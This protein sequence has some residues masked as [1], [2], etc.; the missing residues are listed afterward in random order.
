[1]KREEVREEGWGGRCMMEGKEWVAVDTVAQWAEG[2]RR[3]KKGKRWDR[4]SIR[5]V[6][7]LLF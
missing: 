4:R 1:M 6:I 5:F 3:E 7:S 2:A